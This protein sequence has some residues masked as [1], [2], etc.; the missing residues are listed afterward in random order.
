MRKLGLALGSGAARGWSHIGVIEALEEEGIHAD[1]VTGTSIGSIVGAA[2]AC[3]N[4]AALKQAALTLDV[5][6]ILLHFLEFTVPRAG[7]IDGAKVVEFIGEQLHE[8]SIE[9]L[10]K[11]FA[12]VA[13]DVLSGKE[14][15]FKSGELLTA[16]RASISMPG[17]FAPIYH[18]G[19]V[20]IDGGVVN[21]VPV[22]LA[23]ELGADIV[24]AVDINHGIVH[25]GKKSIPTNHLQ[26]WREN[27]EKTKRDR[28]G[29][30]DRF[31][32]TID[33]FDADKLGPMKR[34]IAPDPIPNIFDVL[35]NSIRI[36]EAQITESKLAVFPPNILIR[37]DVADV[38]IL[39]FNRAE[40][41]IAA[42]YAA[43]REAMPTI[44]Q[45]LEG[46]LS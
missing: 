28:F 13:T 40:E 1:I 6:T 38:D 27:S 26:R 20:L 10:S 24:I 23:R 14:Y 30:V 15:V 45:V 21:P 5:K 35:G 19:R 39:E 42:G 25:S 46:A 36:M 37:P 12:C 44:K 29:I 8:T 32:Q 17:I 18:D 2:Y 33:N 11:P 34:Y 41:T 3:N 9:A 16:I 22:D 4:I 31:Q 7:L 43:T